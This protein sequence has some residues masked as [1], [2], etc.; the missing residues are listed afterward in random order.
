MKEINFT[1]DEKSKLST[2]GWTIDQDGFV[3]HT[4]N[5]EF[6]HSNIQKNADGTLSYS[7]YHAVNVDVDDGS[8][9]TE[10][11]SEIYKSVDAFVNFEKP[12][13]QK[14]GK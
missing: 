5:N 4:L 10:Y 13:I 14:R 6:T 12:I 3:W 8:Y 11:F 2:R 9:D 7:G 1:E